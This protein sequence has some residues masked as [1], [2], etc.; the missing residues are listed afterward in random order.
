MSNATAKAPAKTKKNALSNLRNIGIIAHIDAGKTTVTERILFY[1]GRSRNIGEVH[2]GAATMDHLAEERER[3]ITITSAATTCSWGR[4]TINIIDTPGHVDFTAEVERSLRVL[5]GAVAV[6]DGV[7]GVE[8]QSETVWRQADK[9]EVP[10]IAFVNK[11]DRTGASFDFCLESMRTRLG[12]HPVPVMLNIGLEGDY[13]GNID[14][15]SMKARYFG[16]GDDDTSFVE[17]EIP[18]ELVEAAQTARHEMIEAACMIDDNL[19]ERFLEDET[20]IS[21]KEIV[22]ALRLGTIQ[23]KMLVVLCGAALRNKGVQA[24][25]DAICAYLPSP[26]DQPPV[27]GTDAKGEEAQRSCDLDQPFSALAFKTVFDPNGDLTFMRV[28]SGKV[29]AGDQLL[30]TRTGKKERLGRLYRMHAASREPIDSCQAGDIIAAVGLKNTNT[31]DT[32]A[33]TNNPITL[34]SVEFPDTVISMS[35]EPKSKGDRDKL[36]QTLAVL[37]KEDPTFRAWTDEETN[38]TIIAGMGELHLEVLRHRIIR[39]FKVAA[40][41]GKPRVAYRQTINEA[42]EGV[43]GKHVKQTGGHGQFAVVKMHFEALTDSQEIEFVDDIKGGAVP[44]EY[45]P[46]VGKGVKEASV[47][48]REYPFPFVG[49]RCSLYDG[50]SHDVDSSDM[51]F[52]SAGRIA[53]QAAVAGNQTFLEPMMKIEVLVPEDNLGDVIGDLNSRRA[54]IDEIADRAN[55]KVITGMVPIAET[56]NYSS[57]LRSL[58]AGRGTYSMEPEGY[59]PVPASVRESII[60]EV[61]EMRKA[62]G[63]G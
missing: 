38:E 7:A 22:A 27:N 16:D 55:L 33:D 9:Y 39:E 44:R 50:K 25:L 23:R 14:L 41:C 40:E 37:A 48:G 51:A 46:S 59:A 35:I 3:G 30:N 15:I 42:R 28:Y 18:A 57:K 53:F 17:K 2:D 52:Q 62:A 36:S 43:E 13:V 29:T 4:H 1:T 61:E 21:E 45:I 19:L 60:K 32:L 26:L 49:V 54:A 10:R 31:G 12:V 6:F 47:K 24:T 34:E 5:D 56:F 11:L 58:T 63:K 8:A 20:Q